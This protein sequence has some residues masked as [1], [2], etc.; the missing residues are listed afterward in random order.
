MAREARKKTRHEG[1]YRMSDG[2]WQIRVTRR[3]PQGKRHDRLRYLE[4]EVSLE[5][6]ALARAELAAE[7]AGDLDLLAREASPG[8]R[9]TTLSDYAERWLVRKAPHLL[10]GVS[11]L[12]GGEDHLLDFC[13]CES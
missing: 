4:A 8:R 3:D 12:G 10:V 7:L 2:R 1:V 5:A 9:P 13:V 6:A 11:G